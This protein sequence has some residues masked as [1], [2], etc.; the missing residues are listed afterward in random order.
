MLKTFP[1]YHQ[2]DFMDCGPTCLRIIAKYYGRAISLP[3]LRALS[4]TTREGSSLKN[5]A[6]TAEKIGFRTLGVKITFKKLLEEAPLP[7]IVHWNQQHFVV[8]YRA[9][10]SSPSADGG[11]NILKKLLFVVKRAWSGG[12]LPPSGELKGASVYISDPA[13]GLLK[14][15]QAEFIKNWIGNNANENT[16]EGIALLLEPTPKL[17]KAETDDVENRQGISFLFDY[18]SKYKKFIFQLTI[19]LL[20]GSLLQLIFPFLTQSIVDIGIQNRDINFSYLILIA[21]L[22]YVFHLHYVLYPQL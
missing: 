9:S 19:G 6:T 5:I 16:E 18:L 20:A 11:L 15:T 4:E 2:P 8:V 17:K 10:P 1:H 14:Y 3:K 13:H 22:F 12:N 21:Q 7:C